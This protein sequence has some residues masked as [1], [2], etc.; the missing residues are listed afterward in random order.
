MTMRTIVQAPL[1][2]VSLTV[3]NW[4]AVRSLMVRVQAFIESVFSEICP[5]TLSISD[6]LQDLQKFIREP[7]R[8]LE[9]AGGDR[10]IMLLAIVSSAYFGTWL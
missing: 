7:D 3:E 8:T 2:S 10:H 9:E 1:S 6:G 4:A 5:A